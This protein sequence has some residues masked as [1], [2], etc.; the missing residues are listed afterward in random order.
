MAFHYTLVIAMVDIKQDPQNIRKGKQ[1]DQVNRGL[2]RCLG[3]LTWLFCC[4]LFVFCSY[5]YFLRQGLTD[6]VQT[7]L[8]LTMLTSLS[9]NSAVLLPQPPRC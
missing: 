9:L 1:Y 8:E 5:F 2:S 4:C 3:S 6:I 7:V